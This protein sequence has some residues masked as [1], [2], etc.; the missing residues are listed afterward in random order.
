MSGNETAETE[1]CAVRDIGA[2]YY[3]RRR[4]AVLSVV[5]VP[6]DLSCAAAYRH[7]SDITEKLQIRGVFN[8]SP[9]DEKSE[10][11]DLGVQTAVREELKNRPSFCPMTVCFYY[12]V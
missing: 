5:Q 1:L 11:A 8:E 7:R 6:A 12:A 10:A 2:V 3:W 4:M 9:C